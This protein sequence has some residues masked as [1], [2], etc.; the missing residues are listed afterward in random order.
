MLTSRPMRS[1]S[2]PASSSALRPARVAASEACMPWSHRRRAWMPAMSPS[3]SARIPKRSSVGCSRSVISLEVSVCGASM[4]ASPAIETFWKCMEDARTQ[5]KGALFYRLPPFDA[6][7][8]I[9]YPGVW[10]GRKYR[11]AG[12][13]PVMPAAGRQTGMPRAPRGCRPAVGLVEPQR[14]GH[15]QAL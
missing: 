3:M 10:N 7:L 14:G 11:D 15:C 12:Q 13:S 1:G 8:T 4:C 9:H 6:S 2:T 5:A